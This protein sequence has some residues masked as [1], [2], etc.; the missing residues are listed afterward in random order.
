MFPSKGD[1]K[2][3]KPSSNPRKVKINNPNIPQVI[4]GQVTL[5]SSHGVAMTHENTGA[6]PRDGIV[7]QRIMA[8]IEYVTNREPKTRRY[9]GDGKHSDEEDNNLQDDSCPYYSWRGKR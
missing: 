5:P 7:R 2:G 9:F 3:Q 6:N 8:S 1:G 4:L